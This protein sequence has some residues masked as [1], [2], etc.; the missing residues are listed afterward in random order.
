[1]DNLEKSRI[2]SVKRTVNMLIN[3]GVLDPADIN[4]VTH[5]AAYIEIILQQ[6]EITTEIHMMLE[7]ME[8]T[9]NKTSD[10]LL[11]GSN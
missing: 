10:D 4:T 8:N 1:M 2:E 11:S 6:H 7:D 9:L 5:V 3:L